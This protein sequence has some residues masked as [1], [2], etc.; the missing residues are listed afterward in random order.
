VSVLSRSDAAHL[1]RRTGFG[2]TDARLKRLVGLTRAG[3]VKKVLEVQRNPVP[4]ASPAFLT[5]PSL[6]MWQRYNPALFWWMDRMA[7]VPCPIEEKLTL[8][9][10]GHFV[11]SLNKVWDIPKLFQQ[12]QLYRR[13]ALG[14]YRDLVQEMAKDPAMLLYLD[15]AQNTRH[16]VQE[17]FG[18]E[19]LELFC[20]GTGN[21]SESDVVAMSRAWTGHGLDSGGTSYR[22]NPSAH[23]GGSKTLF[24]ITRN[25]DGPA[26][27]DEMLLG[28]KAEPASRWITAKLFSHLAFPVTPDAAVVGKL[29]ANFRTWGLDL[30]RLVRAILMSDQFWSSRARFALVRQPTEFFVAGMEALGLPARE[31]HPEWYAHHTTQQLLFPPNVA[32]WGQNG[33]HVSTANQWAKAGY[34]NHLRWIARDRGIFADAA[35]LPSRKAVAQAFR[36]F[37]VTDPSAATTARLEAWHDSIRSGPHR[38]AVSAGLVTGVMLSPDFQ[39]A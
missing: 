34:A 35:D 27:I 39:I 21:Y 38:W 5:D 32:G 31:A 16:G 24:G 22:F 25:W 10:H 14:N 28:S 11:S 3:A 19:L 15:N 7:T 9:W 2:V 17:N 4:E 8:F 30:R 26:A 12:T 6:E 29:A 23:D 13:H 18:R 36:R 1:V 37:G 33:Y 20:L